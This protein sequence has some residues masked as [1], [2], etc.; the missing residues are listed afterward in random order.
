MKSLSLFITILWLSFIYQSEAQNFL[1]YVSEF[2]ISFYC[3]SFYSTDVSYFFILKILFSENQSMQFGGMVSTSNSYA[4]DA[5][6]V[7]VST[8]Q[9][10]LWTMGIQTLTSEGHN[11]S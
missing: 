2:C 10:L 8:E 9:P 6:E 4:P 5:Q 3:T 1:L 11:G 7:T